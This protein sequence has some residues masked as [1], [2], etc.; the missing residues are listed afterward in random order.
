M[1]C[2][3]ANL[4][5]RVLVDDGASSA[6]R[7]Q[8]LSWTAAGERFVAPDL[9][10]YEVTNALFKY[11]RVGSLTE[12]RLRAAVARVAGFPIALHRC[13]HLHQEAIALARRFSLPATYDAHYL[14]LAQHLGAELWTLD[15]RLFNAVRAELPWVHLAA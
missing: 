3:D 5:V 9:F 1:I 4:V 12:E 10:G 14:A 6:V 15:Q 8:W 7:S 13:E 11:Y 2:L